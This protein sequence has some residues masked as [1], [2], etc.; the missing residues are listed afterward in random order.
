M[1]FR[2]LHREVWEN[3]KDDALLISYIVAIQNTQELY[4]ITARFCCRKDRRDN[5]TAEVLRGVAEGAVKTAM[6]IEPMVGKTSNIGFM[7]VVVGVVVG[8]FLSAWLY[9][10]RSG[11]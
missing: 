11:K 2:I 6:S 3:R 8:A 4:R 7:G 5:M 10:L 1:S 9:F